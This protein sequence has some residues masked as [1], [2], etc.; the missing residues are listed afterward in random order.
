MDDRIVVEEGGGKSGKVV[1]ADAGNGDGG[2]G[3]KRR[4]GFWAG[5]DCDLEVVGGVVKEGVEDVSSYCARGLLAA[6][7]PS[8]ILRSFQRMAGSTA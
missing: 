7:R 4:C 8:V 3:G 2:M 6:R 5:Q 1:V